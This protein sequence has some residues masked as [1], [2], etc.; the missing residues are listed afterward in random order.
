VIAVG[1]TNP[2]LTLP[3]LCSPL[4]TDLLA[5]LFMGVTD[6]TG[7]IGAGGTKSAGGGGVFLFPNVFGGANLYDAGPC[8]RSRSHRDPDRE[9]RTAGCSPPRSRTCPVW[10]KVTR[11]FSNDPN[12]LQP[13]AL[14]HLH[15]GRCRTAS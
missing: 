3:G 11:L 5:T 9:Q 6:A 13:H 8:A 12:P 2:S 10:V 1:A 7:Y 15:P 14:F 4:Y